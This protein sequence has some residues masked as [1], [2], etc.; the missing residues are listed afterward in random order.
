M[1]ETKLTP[2]QARQKK[3]TAARDKKVAQAINALRSGQYTIANLPEDMRKAILEKYGRATELLMSDPELRKIFF[4]QRKKDGTLEPIQNFTS[5]IIGSQWL[6][7]RNNNQ[8]WY[9][10]RKDLPDAKAELAFQKNEIVDRVKRLAVQINGKS[11]SDIEASTIAEDL[12]RN[13]NNGGTGVSESDIVRK[14]QSSAV[15]ADPLTFG[16]EAA[17][18]A[19]SIRSFAANMGVSITDEKIGMYVD[20]IFE[21][22]QTLENVENLLRNNA[23]SYYGANKAVADRIRAG[24]SVTDIFRMQMD[25]VESLHEDASGSVKLT[26]PR[27][28]AIISGGKDG[29]PM[30][31]TETRRY[32]K[33]L[34][35]YDTTRGAQDEYARLTEQLMR[36]FG[37]GV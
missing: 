26:D 17:T 16:G 8:R 28:A 35:Q 33:S 7:T 21:G 2:E 13:Y 23:I 27:M 4:S 15:N 36:T 18:T 19:S 22:K 30:N 25:L 10:S 1:A 3:A 9:D 34:P 5:K 20:D 14:V 12:L 32:L 24:E 29:G 6:A 31:Y 11:L 37:A